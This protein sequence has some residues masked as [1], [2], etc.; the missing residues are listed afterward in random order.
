M[1]IKILIGIIFMA[2]HVYAGADPRNCSSVDGKT[3]LDLDPFDIDAVGYSPNPTYVGSLKLGDQSFAFKSKKQVDDNI[4]LLKFVGGYTA[5]YSGVK[6]GTSW[7]Y[8]TVLDRLGKPAQAT[9]C[10]Q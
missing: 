9:E 8:L 5:V 2:G 10:R 3:F 7:A 1:K 6:S 4:I